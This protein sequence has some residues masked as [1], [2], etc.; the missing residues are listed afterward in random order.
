[1][2]RSE[3][4]TYNHITSATVENL[5]SLL[6]APGSDERKLDRALN[7]D[8]D[9]LIADLEDAVAPD[10]KDGARETVRRV[11]GAA[12]SS[13]VARVVRVNGADSTHFAADV[14]AIQDLPL[15]AVVLPKASVEAVDMLGPDG[16]PV[17]AL[18]ESARGLRQSFEIATRPRVAALILGSADLGAELGLE[19]RRDGLELLYARSQLVVDSAAAGIRA[20]IDVVHLDISD[21]AGLE[22]EARLARSLGFTGKTCIHPRQLPIVNSVFEPGEEEISWATSVLAAYD[23]GVREGRGAVSVGGEMIDLAVVERARR[24]LSLREGGRS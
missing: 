16:P 4:L 18:I 15:D 20:P 10:Q 9:A 3:C 7:S 13:G 5:R 23:D 6:F 11:L 17:L 19:P 21:D 12:P 24:V 2:T 1:M 22:E 8:A 14:S